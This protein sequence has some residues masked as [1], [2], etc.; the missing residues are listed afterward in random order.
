[1]LTASEL[2]GF[3]AAHAVWSLADAETFT[4]MLAYTTEDGQRKMERLIG[5]TEEE[6]VEY[7]RQQLAADPMGANDAALLF[8][9]RLTTDAGKVDAII[10]EM[11]CYVA[12]WVEATIGVPYTPKSAGQF[13]VHRPKLVVW[14]DCNDFDIDAVFAAFFRGVDAHTEGAK[15]WNAALDQSR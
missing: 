14:K 4:P 6:A 5:R 8:D 11:R 9:G 1:M 7:G 2:A 10:I 3:F 13:R 15:V 12:P